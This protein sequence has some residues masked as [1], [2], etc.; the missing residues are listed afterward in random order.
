MTCYFEDIKS[1]DHFNVKAWRYGGNPEIVL[2][3]GA[4][5]S[6]EFF[7]YECQTGKKDRKGWEQI[8][9]EF[10]VTLTPKDGKIGVFVWNRGD[11]EGWVDDL[12]I[13]K[14]IRKK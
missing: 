8:F 10:T 7:Y 11:K 3:A 5:D 1:G 4:S 6:K 13:S 2:A 9:I 14:Y 12:I